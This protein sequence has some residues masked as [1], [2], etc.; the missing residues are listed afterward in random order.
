M[1]NVIENAKKKEIAGSKPYI[2]AAE[3]TLHGMI[4]DLDNVVKK[5]RSLSVY[6]VTYI[7][8]YSCI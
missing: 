7:S 6:S 5:V 8:V 2:T 3:G 4:V 1:K